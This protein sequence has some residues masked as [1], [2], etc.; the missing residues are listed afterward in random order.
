MVC[1]S[2]VSAKTYI[3]EDFHGNELCFEKPPQRIISLA[4]ST[5]EIIYGLNGG[6]RLLAITDES[7]YPENAKSKI[8]VGGLFLNYEKIVTLE[9]DLVILEDTLRPGEIKK[10]K[11]LKLPVLVVRSDN[12]KNFLKSI[13]IISCALGQKEH[14]KREI[15]ELQARLG[16]IAQCLKGVDYSRRPTIFIEIWNQPLMTAGSDTFINHVVTNAGGK[17][18][19]SDMRGYPQINPESLLVGNPD[20]IILTTSTVDDFQKKPVWKNLKAVRNNRVYYVNPDI[21]VRPTMRLF[22][23]AKILY[24]IF[25]PDRIL[26]NNISD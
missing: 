25:Y 3:V 10:L 12:Y 2:G 15:Q 22:E 23:G 24:N 20:I 21:L 16:M 13:E 14:G 4:P 19:F 26:T 8:S 18:L 17:N 9:P 6:G 7:N 5:T 1:T 11:K